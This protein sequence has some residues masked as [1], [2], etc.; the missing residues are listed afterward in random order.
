MS[1]TQRRSAVRSSAGAVRR[2]DPGVGRASVP[3][4]PAHVEAA[5]GGEDVE[6]AGEQRPLGRAL[7]QHGVAGRVGQLLGQ[8][9]QRRDAD[10]GA[11]QRDLRAGSRARAV[12]RPYGPS[13]STRVPGRRRASRALP[14][15]SAL[16]VM[17]RLRPSGAAES[18]YG[19]PRVQPGP[20]RNRQIR[21]WPA[22]T[23]SRSSPRPVM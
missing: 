10:A 13:T 17:R 23:G 8:R 14:S 3:G 6:L 1:G 15:P 22:A 7:Q 5:F 9:P 11:E 4:Q 21:N 12:S 19:W 18:E 2:A 16:T 20:A